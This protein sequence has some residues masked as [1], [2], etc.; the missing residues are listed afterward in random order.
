MKHIRKAKGFTLI[1][2]IMVIVIIGILAAVAIPKYVALQDDARNAATDGTAG[3]VRAGIG[4]WHAN[5]LVKGEETTVW[6]DQLDSGVALATTN[7]FYSVLDIPIETGW[8]KAANQTYTAPNKRV[9]TY[10][11]GDGKFQ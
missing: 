3:G 1:E 4:I 5:I 10:T 6:P 11:S 7:L 9:F 8:T 2:L